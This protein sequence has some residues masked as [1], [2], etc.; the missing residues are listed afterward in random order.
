MMIY[1]NIVK[2]MELREVQS[3]TLAE[4]SNALANSFGPYGS[5]TG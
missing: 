2:K 4:I 1:S 3:R 5:T